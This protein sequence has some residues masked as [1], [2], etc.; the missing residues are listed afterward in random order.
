MES[1]FMDEGE[2]LIDLLL[3]EGASYAE[4]RFQKSV[5]FG[6][7]LKNG[8]PEPPEYGEIYGVAI[9]VLYQ[10]SLAFSSTNIVTKDS[11]KESGLRALKTAKAMKPT[12]KNV[13]FSSEKA[14]VDDWRVNYKI[15]PT[16]VDSKVITE[17]LKEVDGVV[18]GV[19]GVKFPNRLLAFGG[20]VEEKVYMNSEGSRL[21]SKVPRI[22]GYFILTAL[23]EGKGTL[24]RIVQLGETG[25]WDRVDEMGPVRVAKEE[26]EAMSKILLHGKDLVPGRY[27]VVVGGEVSGI[28]AHEAC[29]HPQEAD[30]IL[31]REAAQA[32]ES[33]L[34]KDMIGRKIGSPL[35][36]VTDFPAMPNSNGFYIYDDEGVK[37]IKKELIKGGIINEFL[38]NRETAHDLGTKSN[39][40]M[41]TSSFSRE[42]IVRMSNTFIEPGDHTF[43]E[44]LEGVNHG[45]Y[46]K[47]F[48]EWNIDDIRWNNRYVGLEAY[49]IENGEIKHPVIAPVIEATTGLI[50]SSIDAIGNE[51]VFKANTCGKGQPEQG[52]PVWTGGPSMR[53]KGLSIK[54]R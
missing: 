31:G 47:S 34:K 32:G 51:L 35:V 1:H 25:G 39:A 13:Q 23:N 17:L 36:F 27:D 46:I 7:M 11:M 50:F 18:Q 5:D 4:L 38:H 29:G 40:S 16:D 43:D 28:I 45:L 33:Y 42:P 48:Q 22:G 14:N 44:L 30:R 52:V 10:G 21:K 3:K 53:M 2:W 19:K 15:S 49:A 54:N 12:S 24:Q 20:G 6:I 9:R 37:A 8:A 26:A 41:R